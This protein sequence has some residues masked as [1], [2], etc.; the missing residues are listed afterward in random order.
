[1]P[2]VY[3]IFATILAVA[4]L[5]DVI[6]IL[7]NGNTILS[8]HPLMQ[9]G[10]AS[11]LGSVVA[12][13]LGKE[14]SATHALVCARASIASWI[15]LCLLLV[16]TTHSGS[17]DSS[18]TE[19]D[20]WVDPA[21]RRHRNYSIVHE[22]N[23]LHSAFTASSGPCALTLDSIKY[24]KPAQTQMVVT[25]LPE[26]L[27]KSSAARKEGRGLLGCSR[28]PLASFLIQGQCQCMSPLEKHN[29]TCLLFNHASHRC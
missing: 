27:S 8:H 12:A 24:T 21:M 20:C 9:H 4:E 18:G 22:V 11:L 19:V 10:M 14:S 23:N 7:S 2:R 17:A 28:K 16:L 26:L 29:F 5:I 15:L 6:K 1:M 25:P 3:N 13:N